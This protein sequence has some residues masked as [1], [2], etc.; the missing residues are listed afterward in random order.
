MDSW[1]RDPR[2]AT[3]I[4][5]HRWQSS[6]AAGHGE[7]AFIAL[8]DQFLQPDCDVLNHGCGHGELTLILAARCRTIVGIERIP[9]YLELARALA[10]EQNVW[11][12]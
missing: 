12:Q 4:F 7:D 3:R 1:L 5:A 6:V 2:I 9:E 11:E 10:A 8:I